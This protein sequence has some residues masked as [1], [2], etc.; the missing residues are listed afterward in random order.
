MAD[1][2]PDGLLRH[3][4][5]FDYLIC[6]ISTF[7]GHITRIEHE[8]VRSFCHHDTDIAL[9]PLSTNSRFQ[10]FTQ[11]AELDTMVVAGTTPESIQV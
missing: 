1:K 10:P 7:V 9:D 11:L 4:F 8:A 2:R 6:E 3:A 5:P